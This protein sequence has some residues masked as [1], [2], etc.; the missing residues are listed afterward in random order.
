MRNTLCLLLAVFCCHFTLAQ[1]DESLMNLQIETRLDYQ[2]E[3]IHG[4]ILEDNCGFKGKYL[5]LRIDGKIDDRFSYSYRQR[6][7]KEHSDQSYF[8]ATDWIYLSYK[9]NGHWN[10][11][12]GKQIVGIGGFEYDRAPID[13]YFCSEFWNNI[14]CYQ[15][16]V[17]GNYIFNEG[18]DILMGQI[19][20]SPFDLKNEDMYAFNLM[21]YGS[22]EW[23][24]TIY[25]VNMIE[26]L[27]GKYVNYIA[28]GNK[29]NV[30]DFSFSLDFMNR[31]VDE[32]TFLFRDCSVMGELAYAPSDKVNV[33]AKATYDVNRSDKVSDYCVMSGTEV[34]RVGA[35][36]EFYPLSGG[37]KSIRFHAVAS[38]TFGENSNPVGVLA[39]EQT[40]VD[41]GVKWKI[42]ILSLRNIFK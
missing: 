27:P 20:E 23:F 33:F 39:S 6:L 1:V 2:R 26:Y 32:Q 17:S 25:S 22:H 15:L 36:V 11:S 42:D 31:A 35:G 5:N 18:K 38:H 37:N 9:I 12:A 21:W 13:L 7:N 28:L 16:G 14:P 24:Q 40:Y 19:C 29:F 41:M 4:N 30:G 10:V 3:Y 34:T 8:D